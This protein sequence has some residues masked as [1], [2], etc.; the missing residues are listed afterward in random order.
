MEPPWLG[1]ARQIQALAQT[2]L[3]Y[4]TNPYDIE[5]YHALHALVTGE[6]NGYYE[7]FGDCEHLARAI[8]RVKN[9]EAKPSPWTWPSSPA[10]KHALPL[11]AFALIPLVANFQY[12][13]RAHHKF[14]EQWAHDYLDSLEPYSILIT[15]GDNETFPLWYAQEIEGIRRDVTVA[16]FTYLDTDWYVRQ[17]I[18]RP[19]ETYDASKG[20]AIYR[21]KLWKKPT[22][23]PLKLTLAE[24]D[25]IPDYI[26]I[27]HPQI[28]RQGDINLAI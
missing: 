16:V 4:A 13:S 24:A 3:T 1:W 22:G 21:D 14:T 7:D 6:T 8:D 11:L 17:M 9:R 10:F 28:F 23:P 20:P 18:R 2:G 15:S 27:D 5:R 25:S 26:Q 19:V 12:A